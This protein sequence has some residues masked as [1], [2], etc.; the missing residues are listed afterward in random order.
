MF[1]QYVTPTGNR[2]R[3]KGSGWID[4]QP[5]DCI[6]QIDRD[7]PD[8]PAEL[9]G[10]ALRRAAKE[11]DRAR[12]SAAGKAQYEKR[13]LQDRQTHEADLRREHQA[14]LDASPFA[15]SILGN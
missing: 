7:P 13:R 2:M 9:P 10:V 3:K 12:R 4:L 6:G 14:Y 5:L 11:A 15:P 8:D 1:G